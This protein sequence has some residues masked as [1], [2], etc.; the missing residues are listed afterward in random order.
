MQTKLI[1]LLRVGDELA[2]VLGNLEVGGR[3]KVG[4]IDVAG[5]DRDEVRHGGEGKTIG[6]WR[7]I[8]RWRW[9][10][11]DGSARVLFGE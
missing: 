3:I 11:F 9:G 6:V 1:D 8:L 2:K 5:G 7:W 4:W 10:A